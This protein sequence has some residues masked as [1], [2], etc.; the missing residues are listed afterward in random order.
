MDLSACKQVHT[1]L[2]TTG[3]SERGVWPEKNYKDLSNSVPRGGV[4]RRRG[5]PINGL[6]TSQRYSIEGF[7]GAI[8]G[9][10]V[11]CLV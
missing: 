8:N 3:G 9:G 2:Y 1:F 6:L 10:T 4:F 5:G 7:K 11:L